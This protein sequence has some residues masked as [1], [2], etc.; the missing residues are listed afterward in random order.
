MD[1]QNWVKSFVG[2]SECINGSLVEGWG[3]DG[4]LIRCGLGLDRVAS[5]KHFFDFFIK[6]SLWHTVKI[7]KTGRYFVFYNI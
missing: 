2:V 1:V 7:N 3:V 6:N 5:R 4:C